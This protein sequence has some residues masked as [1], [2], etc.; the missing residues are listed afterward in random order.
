M[1]VIR[2]YI[3]VALLTL[4]SISQTLAQ[5]VVPNFTAGPGNE[6][7]V[8]VF[9]SNPCDGLNNGEITFTIISATGG[10]ASIQ[11]IRQAN[12]F[13]NFLNTPP[14]DTDGSV[15]ETVS[16]GDSFTFTTKLDMSGLEAGNYGFSI[17][18]GTYTINELGGLD[19]VDLT[20][21][22]ALSIVS[23]A[24][25]KDNTT[26]QNPPAGPNG[27]IEVAI[28]GGSLGLSGGG[29]LSYTWTSDNGLTG[30]PLTIANQTGTTSYT[31]NLITDLNNNGIPT[32]GLPGGQY[33]I[34]IEDDYSVCGGSLDINISDPTP[35][36]YN[37]DNPGVRNICAGSGLDVVLLG[38]DP[39]SAPE[40]DVTYT[41][42]I[43]R[44]G[45]NNPASCADCVEVGTGGNLTFS[46]ADSDIQDGDI[47]TI[48]ASQGSCTDQIMNGSITVNIVP[49]P[50]GTI[51]NDGP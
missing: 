34:T 39:S 38:S 31:A 29:S 36:I 7:E 25:T 28:T 47:I 6:L 24:T 23:T 8:E 10:A 19:G 16:V 48:Q 37:I 32:A 1:R 11:V 26:C 4:I 46:L 14:H 51:S 30:L 50:A 40:P 3:L 9:L 15:G 2:N 33:T 20:A 45:S 35:N 17:T 21:L 18:D 13:F 42:F 5:T 49:L 41:I 12:S 43:D 22:S 27:E 44:A